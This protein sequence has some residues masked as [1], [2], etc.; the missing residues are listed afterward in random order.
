MAMVV[1]LEEGVHISQLNGERGKPV[2]LST[3]CGQNSDVE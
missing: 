1:P 3:R 2:E